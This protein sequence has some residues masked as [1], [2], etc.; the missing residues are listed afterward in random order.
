LEQQLEGIGYNNWRNLGFVFTDSTGVLA[1]F[2]VIVLNEAT[3]LA[4]I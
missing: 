3:I 1:L 2:N 4:H